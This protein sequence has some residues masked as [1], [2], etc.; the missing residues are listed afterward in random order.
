MFIRIN[1]M[2]SETVSSYINTKLSNKLLSFET[3]GL[4]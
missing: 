4:V 3:A 2:L 1:Y